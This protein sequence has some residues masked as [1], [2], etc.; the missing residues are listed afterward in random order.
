VAENG[1][2]RELIGWDDARLLMDFEPPNPSV[3][4]SGKTRY[5]MEKIA[6]EPRPEVVAE[7]EY[8]PTEIVGYR[9]EFGP[10][11]ITPYSI[12]V[13]LSD[14]TR[15]TMGI[16]LVGEDQAETIDIPG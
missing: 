14:L 15:G 12:Q 11:V 5:P 4:I 3:I 10:E 1:I 13:P 16:E 7:P 8:W 6:L 9:K 2:I